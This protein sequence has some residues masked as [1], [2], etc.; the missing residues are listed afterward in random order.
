MDATVHVWLAALLHEIGLFWQRAAAGGADYCGIGPMFTTDTKEAGSLAGP[1][2]LREY[3]A[4]AQTARVPHLA[5]GGITPENAGE[6]VGAGC[7]GVAVS[8]AVCGAKEPGE[9]C[10]ALLRAFGS[11][12]ALTGAA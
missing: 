4:A 7:R 12:A 3:M 2:Y 1:A 8:S 9:V 10:G 6:L 5:I 11:K